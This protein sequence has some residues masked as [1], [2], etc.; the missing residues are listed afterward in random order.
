MVLVVLVVLVVR[1]MV[2]LRLD[3]ESTSMDELCCMDRKISYEL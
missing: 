3:D 1:G 2:G